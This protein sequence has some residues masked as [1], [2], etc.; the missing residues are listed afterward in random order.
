MQAAD[1]SAVVALADR[2]VGDGY[3]SR[4]SVTEMLARSTL[5]DVVCSHVA[6]V[7][8]RPPRLVGFRF[9]LP[10]GAWQH[11]RGQTISPELG[12]APLADSGYFQTAFVDDSVRRQGLGSRMATAALDSLRTLGARGVVTH[13]W[14]ES[15]GNSS[16]RYLSRLGFRP[17]VEIANYW[18]DVDYTCVRD[19]HPCH[20]TA[21]EM[22]LPL[23]ALPTRAGLADA[24]DG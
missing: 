8:S 14:K 1:I 2:L 22:Y 10:P 20:C 17:I 6:E 15:P 9:S 5:G 4:A 7:L 11:G 18:I 23:G 21:I 16:F 19:G 3:Y 13:C 24:L 12:P